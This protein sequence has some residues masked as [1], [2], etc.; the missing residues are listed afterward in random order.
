V[1]LFSSP[2][3]ASLFAF[4]FFFFFFP[5]ETT[6]YIKITKRKRKTAMENAGNLFPRLTPF[7]YF[8]LLPCV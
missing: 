6:Q 2:P 3:S 8:Y 4:V 5:P 1:N 7:P